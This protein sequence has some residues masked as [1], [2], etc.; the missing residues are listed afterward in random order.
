MNRINKTFAT[1][2]ICFMLSSVL[3]IKADKH[4]SPGKAIAFMA[5]GVVFAV[6]ASIVHER[7]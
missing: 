1:L 5:G 2:G 3:F 4:D 7:R 6:L